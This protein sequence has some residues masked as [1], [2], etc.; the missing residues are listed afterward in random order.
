MGV[1]VMEI[2]GAKPGNSF[3]AITDHAGQQEVAMN[4]CFSG[5]I[6]RNSSASSTAH[7]SAPTATSAVPA[8][9]NCFMASRSLEGVIPGNWLMKAGA[10]M[11]TTSSPRLMD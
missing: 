6:R 8:K 10:T 2:Y 3:L 9:P 11:A 4:G 7:R 1:M 5:T